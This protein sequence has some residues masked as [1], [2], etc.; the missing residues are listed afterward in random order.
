MKTKMNCPAAVLLVMALA[1]V[2][3]P[4][5]AKTLYVNA[6]TGND[7]VSYAGN[8]EAT[9]WRTLGRAAW[10][11][12][13]RATPSTAEA[14]RAGDT[15]MVAA[16]TYT[17]GGGGTRYTPAFNPVNDGAAGN[18]ITFQAQG[19]VQ[20]AH[21]CGTACPAGSGGPLIGALNRHYIRWLGDFYVNEN[22]VTI[23]A[24]TGAIAVWGSDNVIIDGCRIDGRQ[25]DYTYGDNH[26]GVRIENSSNVT[27]RN[28]RI[29]D[30]RTQMYAGGDLWHHNGAGI[31][32]YGNRDVVMEHNE[33][34]R[35]G[36]GIFVKGNDNYNVT[37]RYNLLHDNRGGV[38]TSYSSPTTGINRIYQNVIR[39]GFA[40]ASESVG[41]NLAEH[42]N[43]CV[44]A[45]N[46]IYHVTNGI[47]FGGG[48]FNQSDLV[49]RNNIIAVTSNAF[50]AYLS[51]SLTFTADTQNYYSTGGWA[52][53]NA[54][55]STLATWRSVIGGDSASTTSN[56]QF[57]STTDL[58]LGPAS[59]VRNAS[60]DVLDLNG[61]G[62][63]TDAINLGAYVTGNE[64]IG[65][66]SS[67]N[68]P[69]P[70]APP[71]SLRVVN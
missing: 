3:L 51:S 19:A 53:N 25:F 63:T 28:C 24:D 2:A 38:R 13:N 58:R 42:S 35:C 21:D 48:T 47:Y 69:I 34:S 67:E 41:I 22:A 10:G 33:I 57:I 5:H 6:S 8:G 50:N 36:A 14:A 17:A 4:A 62:Q 49:F 43:H 52:Y 59:P 11:N 60:V 15:V 7:T 65:P 37:V 64:V 55:H 66:T 70:P 40:N 30:V 32:L 29:R 44:I 27:I 54:I 45:N 31:M 23:R 71:R 56:P 39:D 68:P 20:V 18:Y 12:A 26:N 9:P 61:N 46:T 16:G 1:C